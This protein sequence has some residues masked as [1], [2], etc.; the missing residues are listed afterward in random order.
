MATGTLRPNGAGDETNLFPY[1]DTGEAN[2]EDVDEEV[3]DDNATY[4]KSG[5]ADANWRRDLYNLPA[6]SGSG[7]I[8]KITVYARA[9]TYNPSQTGLKIAI[10][11][12]GTVYES[13][14]ITPSSGSYTTYSNEWADNPNS[15]SAWTW[16]DIDNLQIGVNARRTNSYGTRI[17]KVYVEVDYTPGIEK[18]SSDAGTGSESGQGQGAI[19]SQLV[20]II[21]AELGTS[22]ELGALLKEL[23]TS[24]LGQGTD[25]LAAKIEAPTKG[26]GMKLWI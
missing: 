25:S 6:H 15:G 8:N 13:S 21:S 17:T 26:G 7:T 9:Y 3:A 11:I 2:W 5:T 14:E 18:S 1:P 4:V 23:F 16:D 24:E 19:S 10:K 12:G 22:V 20:A